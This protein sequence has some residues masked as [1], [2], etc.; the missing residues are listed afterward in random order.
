MGI[1]QDA[2]ALPSPVSARPG[3]L[4]RR[5]M[6]LILPLVSFLL[7][8][9]VARQVL[10]TRDGLARAGW[11]PGHQAAMQAALAGDRQRALRQL[12]AAARSAPATFD[13]H[14]R[15][16]IAWE[17][18]GQRVLAVDHLRRALDLRPPAEVTAANYLAVVSQYCEEGLFDRAGQVLS[19]RVLRRWPRD[20]EAHFYQ[21]VVMMHGRKG[22]AGLQNALSIFDRCLSLAPRHVDARYQRGLC[23]ARM[24]RAPEAEQMLRPLL[25]ER[26]EHAG[27]HYAL[28]D[29]LRRQG[30]TAEADRMLDSFQA[31]YVKRQRIDNLNAR[32]TSGRA[33]TAEMLEL[34]RLRLEIDEP[35]EALASLKAY[36]LESPAAPE[37]HRLAARALAQ[38][39]R[40]EEA[41]AERRLAAALQQRPGPP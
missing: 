26:P 23:L 33:T 34:G 17:Y 3:A 36:L 15:L 35:E 22:D 37:G 27:L 16:A 31:L 28:A 12:Q 40:P 10:R 19:A 21:G 9:A 30:K 20:P 18:L 6:L 4:A 2:L 41:A 5:W 14:T 32:L 11:E 8:A 1:Q 7:A 38:M 29:V 24:G 25:R 13:A 39:G